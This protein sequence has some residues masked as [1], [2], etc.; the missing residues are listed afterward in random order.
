MS[1]GGDPGLSF[2]TIEDKRWFREWFRNKYYEIFSKQIW[3]F[4]RERND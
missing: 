3:F 1:F 2:E 4:R